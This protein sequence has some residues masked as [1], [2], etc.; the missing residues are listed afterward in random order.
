MC[1]HTI[2][3]WYNVKL[4]SLLFPPHQEL[5]NPILY[6]DIMRWAWQQDFHHRPSAA[7]LEKILA[8]PSIPLMVDAFNL[9]PY[10]D[11]GITASCTVTL[12]I[13]ISTSSE[14]LQGGP[15]MSPPA[16]HSYVTQGDIQEEVWLCSFVDPEVTGVPEALLS[17]ISFRGRANFCVDV[18]KICSVSV[19][20]LKVPEFIFLIQMLFL[21]IK[22]H[23][24]IAVLLLYSEFTACA[25]TVH[26]HVCVCTSLSVSILDCILICQ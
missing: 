15:P 16:K 19:S 3:I 5:N 9:Q 25:L 1:V 7:Q 11:S 22:Q 24:G 6:L 2:Y 23:I 14:G 12:P 13:D 4:F 8:S 10:C 26:V 17:I 21:L 18:S 20:I